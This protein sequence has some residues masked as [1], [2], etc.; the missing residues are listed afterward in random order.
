M[1]EAMTGKG[2]LAA[3]VHQHRAELLAFLTARCGQAGEAEDILQDMWLKL[4]DTPTGPIQ[5]P[6]SYLFR[7]ANN[8]V[9]DR[10][11]ARHRAMRRDLAWIDDGASKPEARADTA[12]L[13][14]EVLLRAEE[15]G[16]LRRAIASLPP[17]ARRA[18]QLH[19][20]DGHGQAEVAGIMGISRSG[21]EK[22]LATAMRHLRQALA[23]CGY[24]EPAASG[25]QGQ[26]KTAND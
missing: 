1:V 3:L 20:F 17:G 22:H 8:Q 4:A 5:N 23:D 16:V 19:R 13:A 11:R 14:E 10:L 2:G 26:G 18:L 9:L 25:G 6:R 7:V 15:E 12:P 21:V 24:F